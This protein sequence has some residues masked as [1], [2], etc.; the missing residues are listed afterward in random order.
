MWPQVRRFALQCQNAGFAVNMIEVP[1]WI[2]RQF[3][4]VG[5]PAD[6]DAV[7]AMLPENLGR[8]EQ[9]A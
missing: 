3:I 6:I 2:E 4:F 9:L 7:A 1:G 5:P 8:K